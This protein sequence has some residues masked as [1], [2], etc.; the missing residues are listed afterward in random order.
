M[1]TW[2]P[3]PNWKQLPHPE[4]GDIVQLKLTDAFKYLVKAIVIAV[5]DDEITANVEA[6]FDW[7]SKGQITGGNK[8]GVV[9]KQVTFRP[10]FVQ[11][12]VK[13]TTRSS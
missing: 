12:V 6:V 11:N 13:N 3:N 2:E 8:I 5:G 9:G 4:V 10:S 7:Q 1:E